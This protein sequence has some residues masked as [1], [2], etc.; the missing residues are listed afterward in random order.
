MCL[1]VSKARAGSETSEMLLGTSLR[2]L[3]KKEAKVSL[4]EEGLVFVESTF[5]IDFNE[6]N[7][8]KLSAIS[9]WKKI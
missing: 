9:G 7:A 6:R 3:E 8:D 5:S 2:K 1:L 4:Q